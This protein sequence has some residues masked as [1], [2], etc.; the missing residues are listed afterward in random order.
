MIARAKRLHHVRELQQ[1]RATAE[2]AR[3]EIDRR[4]AI[5]AVEAIVD[6]FD[7]LVGQPAETWTFEEMARR[8]AAAH[9]RLEAAEQ[10]CREGA[11]AAV[12]AGHRLHRAARVLDDARA[13]RAD[14][15]LRSEQRALDEHAARRSR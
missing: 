15:I 8:H 10:R 7:A 2:R 13:A 5:E 1:Q 11:I 6:E 3:A 12:A 9:A 4:D 14:R